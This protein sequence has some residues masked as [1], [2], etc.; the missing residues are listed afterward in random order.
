MKRFNHDLIDIEQLV[1]INEDGKR[2]YETPNGN[3]YP[4]V[5]TVLAVLSKAAIQEWRNR[6][7]EKTANRISRQSSSRGT[8]AHKI[9]ERYI[10][11]E[12]NYINGSMPDSVELFKHIQ[13][14]LDKKID[15]VRMIEGRLWSDEYKIAGTVDLIADWD[16]ILSAI[17]WKTSLK[18]VNDDHPKLEKYKIQGT[19]YAKM[20]E[21]RTGIEVP[22]IVVAIMV[23]GMNSIPSVK[24][25]ESEEEN[26]NVLI[27]K[28]PSSELEN[29]LRW[30][31][32]THK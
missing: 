12:D 29:R 19:A 31:C 2:H 4:S 27:F 1:Q 15:N 22:Q 18:H 28:S 16:G 24:F 21:E 11:N 10:S 5:T 8:N 3:K 26:P 9:I 7:G 25:S 6:V 32:E 30:L 20:F 13:P 17:D 14:V 23:S